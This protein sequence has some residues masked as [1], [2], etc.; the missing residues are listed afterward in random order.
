M[1]RQTTLVGTGLA[2]LAAVGRPALGLLATAVASLV[3]GVAT[4]HA[5]GLGLGA[6]LDVLAV[7]VDTLLVL[8]PVPASLVVPPT[9][10][11]SPV[12]LALFRRLLGTAAHSVEVPDVGH[13]AV[14]ALATAV[15]VTDLLVG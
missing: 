3:F 13:R 8:V 2:L 1:P 6:S 11:A 12:C 10:D 7:V 9:V 5:F 4:A 15:S 14:G